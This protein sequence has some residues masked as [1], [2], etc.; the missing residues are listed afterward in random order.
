MKK[1]LIVLLT[2]FALSACTDL[3]V[4]NVDTKNPSSVPAGTLFANATVEMFDYMVS[5]N[6]NENN[7]RLWSQYWTETTYTDEANYDLVTRNSNG[8]TW[9]M[10]YATVIR[11][12][13][14]AKA[15]IS[16]DATLLAADK[17]AQMAMCDVLE[18]YSFHVLVDLF[19][20]VPYSAALGDDDT[21]AYDDAATI[22]ADL[23]ARL[24][25][26]SNDLNGQTTMGA[27]DLIY[28]GDAT[29]W[30]KFAN[31]LRLRIA[32]RIADTDNATAKTAAEAAVA[33]GVFTSS[34]DDFEIAYQNAPPNT[35]PLW[36][37]L[38]QSG[39]DDFVAANT[40]VDYMNTLNDPRRAAYFDA[41]YDATTG[42]PIGGI[43][44]ANSP[45]SAYS[46][47][48]AIMHEPTL[49]GTIMDYTEVEFLLA[50][51]VSRGYSVGGGTVEAHY[52]AGINSSLAEWGVSAADATTY[53]T[54]AS[55]V[56]AT[57]AGADWKQ[58]I[59]MQKWLALYN[60]GFEGYATYR[61]YD[62]PTLN[63]AA[64]VGLL[65]PTRYT[66]PVTEYSLNKASIDAAAAAIGGDLPTT[67]I[68]WDAN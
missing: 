11:D 13:R 34:A 36:E 32:I 29:K 4:V 28:G 19:G 57:A 62:Y 37:D 67:K 7:L 43:Y 18:I 6:V 60:R 15:I 17:K 63:V 20:N 48:G 27:S 9:D 42:N 45:F 54:Q 64:A 2:T 31:S 50:D 12:G 26:V 10:L 47:V 68:F 53:V 41:P 30:K 46:H 24:G 66:Y 22:Y 52:Y 51:A 59:A 35:N 1:I 40:V 23:L 39:R 61:L 44:G 33:A 49:P 65:P 8:R 16:A 21:P 55:V 14:A 38:V 3:T 56:Y 25:T 5:T 58:K